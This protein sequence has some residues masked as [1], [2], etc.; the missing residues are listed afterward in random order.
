MKRR[1]PK[2]ERFIALHLW[3][4]RSEAWKASSPNV[5]VRHVRNGTLV[6]M[7]G[8]DRLIASRSKSS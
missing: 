1:D 3:M 8:L 5:W 6:L 7:A 2:G 4:L